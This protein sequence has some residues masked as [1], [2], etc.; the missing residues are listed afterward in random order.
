MAIVYVNFDV[1][2]HGMKLESEAE[3]EAL[4]QRIKQLIEENHPAGYSNILDSD[5]EVEITEHAG[6]P[7]AGNHGPA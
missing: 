4:R 7:N 1:S 5:V 2:I 3:M 6:T